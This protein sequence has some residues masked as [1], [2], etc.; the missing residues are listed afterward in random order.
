MVEAHRELDGYLRDRPLPFYPWL[1][2]ITW[3]RLLALHHRHLDA[4]R[5]SVGREASRGLGLPE[6]SAW[7]LVERLVSSA[8]SPS[9][10]LLR[11]E[12]RERVR[13]ALERLTPNDCEVLV[14]RHLE[15]MSVA[16][17][18]SVMGIAKGAVKTRHTRALMRL[19]G[20]L[21]EGIEEGM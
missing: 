9:R 4:R 12:L 5:R 7:D 2:R 17:V 3:E 6:E 10:R 14:L 13:A 16:E 21:D 8:T 20:V 18:A 1:R 19:R 15:G 11:A